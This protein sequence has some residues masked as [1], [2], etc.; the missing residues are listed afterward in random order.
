MTG[1]AS[2]ADE[3]LAQST[4][5]YLSALLLGARINE[6]NFAEPAGSAPRVLMPHIKCS[7]SSYSE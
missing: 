7:H 2:R 3:L 6:G 4:E 5:A 1:A